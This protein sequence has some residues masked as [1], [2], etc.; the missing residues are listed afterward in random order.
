M[1]PDI[2][3]IKMRAPL[4]RKIFFCASI[5]T[6][7]ICVLFAFRISLNNPFNTVKVFINSKDSKTGVINKNKNPMYKYI[8]QWTSPRN[9]PFD[10]MGIGQQGFTSR[11]CSYTNC[12]VTSEKYYL[13]DITDFD[14]IAFAGPE[15]VSFPD[16]FLPT[17]RAHHQKYVFA[18]IESS[19]NYPICSNRFDGF[20]NWSWTFRLDSDVRW[21]YMDIKDS[22]NKIIGPN[23]V[24]H[25]MDLKDMKPVSEEF[26]QKL[27]SKRIAAAWFVSNC[28]DRSGRFLLAQALEHELKK[29]NL[30]LNVFGDC[31]KFACPQ[32]RD[33]ICMKMLGETYFFYLSF[34]NS[35]SK[36]YVTEKLLKA[37][38]TNVVPIV[39]G[40]ANYTRY[41]FH[42]FTT[43]S[44]EEN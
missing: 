20:F 43:I 23:E 25:W 4:L 28:F 7:L 32:S 37:L 17:R 19:Y 41:V 40:G 11:N 36:D 21:G 24:M 38:Q 26:K 29:Y 3:H 8:L 16:I 1:P 44:L 34:E 5:V 6:L 12:I 33:E 31:G 10:S 35:I 13:N 9:V 42:Y 27:K 18:S 30:E 15:I 14:V 39:F 22:N 2:K